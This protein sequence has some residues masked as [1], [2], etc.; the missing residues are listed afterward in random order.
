[1][2]A[3]LHDVDQVTLLTLA[4]LGITA[5]APGSAA[6]AAAATTTTACTPND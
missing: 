6:W 2:N 1:M 4:R 5:G 3:G